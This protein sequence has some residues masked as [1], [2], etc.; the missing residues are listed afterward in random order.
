ME[1]K[2]RLYT[3][4]NLNVRKADVADVKGFYDYTVYNIE[5]EVVI[6][7]DDKYYAIPVKKWMEGDKLDID[8]FEMIEQFIEECKRIAKN[9]MV[10][11]HEDVNGRVVGQRDLNINEIG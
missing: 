3:I 5:A 6:K 2:V 1:T 8:F 10:V 4:M 11:Y 7:R 9:W